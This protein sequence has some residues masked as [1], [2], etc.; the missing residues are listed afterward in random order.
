MI[1]WRLPVDMCASASVAS[2]P[3]TVV[4]LSF[5][6]SASTLPDDYATHK[7]FPSMPLSPIGR[8]DDVVAVELGPLE[9]PTRASAISSSHNSLESRFDPGQLVFSLDAWP[10][11]PTTIP[12]RLSRRTLSVG[13]D[14][15][16]RSCTAD[17]WTNTPGCE[18][19]KRQG[20][21]MVVVKGI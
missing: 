7:S 18:V 11:T 14:A 4:D 16:V 20:I 1:G 8:A 10:R 15:R 5:I 3:I 21:C 2:L 6:P 19:E 13:C 17:F 9:S 12:A